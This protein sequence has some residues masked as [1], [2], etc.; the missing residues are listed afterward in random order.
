MVKY[1]CDMC[2][3]EVPIKDDFYI[4]ELSEEEEGTFASH[5]LRKEICEDCYNKIRNFVKKKS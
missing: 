4:L 5:L 3:K 1:Y 2:G